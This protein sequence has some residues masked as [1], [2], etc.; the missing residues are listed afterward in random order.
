[1]YRFFF[2]SSM[3]KKVV[4]LVTGMPGSRMFTVFSG[5]TAP[6]TTSVTASE[7]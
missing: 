1:M 3:Q 7:M 5:V 4:T 6:V 2:F